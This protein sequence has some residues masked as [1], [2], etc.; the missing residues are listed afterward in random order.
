MQVANGRLLW[1]TP[2]LGSTLVKSG[3]LP[4]VVA[5]EKALYSLCSKALKL[6]QSNV[7]DGLQFI[8]FG[9][10]QGRT[11]KEIHTGIDQTCVLLDNLKVKCWGRN[12]Y[13]QLGLNPP[14]CPFIHKSPGPDDQASGCIFLCRA[15]MLCSQNKNTRL[16]ACARWANVTN[17]FW[18]RCCHAMSSGM[19]HFVEVVI[20]SIMPA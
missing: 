5:E 12:E 9:C 2:C 11:A 7:T 16:S 18:K 4:C 6:P 14:I 3:I 8:C 13:G 20:K 19:A 15:C 17:A 10:L 1:G